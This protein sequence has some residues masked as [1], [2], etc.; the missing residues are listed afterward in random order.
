MNIKINTEKKYISFEIKVQPKAKKNEIII[1]IG[2]CH[3]MPLLYIKVTAPPDKGK[4]NEAVIKLIADKLNIKK[5]YVFILRGETNQNK[6]IG[7]KITAGTGRPSTSSGQDDLSLQI[8]NKL[9]NLQIG[10]S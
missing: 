9:K 5:S 4:A 8:Q 10:E 1:N 3:G 6:V 2:A 7:I